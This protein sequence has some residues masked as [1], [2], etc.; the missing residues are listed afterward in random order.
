MKF[1]KMLSLALA[2]AI[3]VSSVKFS[4]AASALP[5]TNDVKTTITESVSR[6]FLASGDKFSQNGL[7][8]TE[9]E[10]GSYEVGYDYYGT[11]P[12]GTVVI[13][14]SV[15]G[16]LVTR[17]A[18][19]GFAYCSELVNVVVPNCV[20][21]VGANAFYGTKFLNNQAGPIKYAGKVAV[22]CDPNASTAAIDPGT[23][24]LADKLFYRSPELVSAT[25]PAGLLNLGSMT[26]NDCQNLTTVNIPE[27][28]KTIGSGVFA[29][30]TSLKAVNIPSGVTSI[31]AYAFYHTALSNVTIP[32]SV[33]RI[34]KGAFE[35]SSLNT[36]GVTIGSGY[37]DIGGRAFYGTPFYGAQGNIKYAG[38]VFLGCSS[39]VT[40]LT[41]KEGTTAIA[42]M[43]L[44]GHKNI[45]SITIPS[46]VKTIGADAFFN[47]P[48]LTAITVPE[49]VSSIGE[50][51]FRLCEG[52]ASVSLPMSVKTIG[53]GAFYGCPNLKTVSYPGSAV[54]WAAGISMGSENDSLL[55]VQPTLGKAPKT[56]API[57]GAAVTNTGSNSVSLS[58][59]KSSIADNYRIDVLINGNW[60]TL[61]RTN[62]TSFTAN[63]LAA[64]TEYQ[65]RIYALARNILSTPVGISAKTRV[66]TV[67]NVSASSTPNSVT[68]SW[69]AVPNVDYYLVNIF[70]DGQW[71]M[72]GRTSSN[73][74]TSVTIGGLNEKTTYQF[75][76]WAFKGNEYGP[77]VAV[78]A[79]TAAI[80]YPDTVTGLT[81]YGSSTNSISL[82]WNLTSTADSY[83]ID[84]YKNGKWVYVAKISGNSYT[85]SG[86]S[87]NTSYDFKVFSFRGS[88]YS[89]SAAVTAR[90]ATPAPAAPETVT[91][92]KASG[93]TTSSLTLSWNKTSTAD[94]YEIDMY[95]NGK[96]VYVAKI[97][98]N[99]YTVSGLS[100]NT[101]YDFKVFSFSGSKYSN[102]ARLTAKT[103]SGYSGTPATVTGLRASSS[104]SSS[105]TLSWNKTSTADSYE[106]DMYKN[107]KWVYVA[108]ISG[109]SYTV[110]G[111]SANTSYDFKVFSFSGSKYSNSARLTAKTASG[112]S[113]T[114]ATVT[115]LRASSSTS[116]SVTLSWNKTS[117][118]DSYEIDMY[119]NGKWVYVAKIS[120]NSY[121]VSGLS[122]N[123]SYDFKVFSFNGSKYSNSARIS[124]RTRGAVLAPSINYTIAPENVLPAN[125]SNTLVMMK[126]IDVSG[127]QGEIDFKAVKSSGIDFVI[128][129]AGEGDVIVDTWEKNFKNAKDAGL[130]VGAY[131]FCTSTTID[132][133][134]QE[135]HKFIGAL[136][137]KQ[138]DFPVYLD[139][140]TSGQFNNGK[141]F[142]TQLVEA[143]CSE[144]EKAGYYAGVYCS[145]YWY[146][147][148]VDDNIRMKRPN[149][150]A[151]YDD[152][153]YYNGSFGIWQFGTDTVPGVEFDCDRNWGYFDYSGY[154]KTHKLNGF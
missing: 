129:K 46:S 52:L 20:I 70:K 106:I 101:S 64:Y 50:D 137:G 145:T 5:K 3:T 150:I 135:A 122:A 58:W 44:S 76:I 97:S 151:Q 88:N 12:V 17:I 23:L 84:M 27:S 140:E 133:A 38:N 111:L 57:T 37:I 85:V 21:S 2:A 142:C 68:L 95:K 153:C 67:S 105:V 134:I 9:L 47:C 14:E 83:E 149:W 26:F 25:L 35:E 98:G 130:M 90:T 55:N 120:G 60:T 7:L 36:N 24:G 117:T 80:I 127:W 16:R 100:A 103:A 63:G 123:T 53:Q 66:A 77:S 96:W 82:S 4:A 78:N 1:K 109:N 15:N 121:T 147:N 107:G 28:I 8:F 6:K 74:K 54:D 91:G 29:D 30:C 62:A 73:T 69:A 71:Q 128:V 152:K 139:M 43:A 138:L 93:A 141:A 102:S 87:A 45:A 131:W 75:K 31:G 148:Y 112:Y 39:N 124:A 32:E 48:K 61:G 146:S 110:S 89:N 42:D 104:T 49:G 143:F 10:D 115:G 116:S 11:K 99:S 40:Q 19:A 13:P 56:P 18:D 114:P 92:L 126:G 33:T 59:N 113:G 81:A 118:A 136:N 125:L 144:L 94:S 86:L 119:K 108:K 34:G 51:A 41:L 65:F 154:I 132:G 79:V 72:A 22:Y